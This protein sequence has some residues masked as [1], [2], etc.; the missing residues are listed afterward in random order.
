MPLPND[1]FSR[2]VRHAWVKLKLHNYICRKCGTGKRNA[3]D[4]SGEW[5]ATYHRATGEIVTSR[6]VPEC[7]V[8][9]LTTER[10]DWLAKRNETEV[11]DGRA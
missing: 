8:G 9:Q 3:Q 10:L 5:F 6:Y 7:E 2:P 11:T 4:R 1:D